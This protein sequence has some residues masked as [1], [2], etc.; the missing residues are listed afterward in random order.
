M[1]FAFA[2]ILFIT[3][4][5]T[6]KKT[7]NQSTASLTNTYWKLSKIN[8]KPVITPENAK[9]VHI[10]FASS[11][12][13]LQGFAG[14]N[15]LGGSYLLTGENNIKINAIT[16]KM[17]CDR[18]EVENFLTN[19]I[20]KADNYRIDGE[21]LSLFEGKKLLATFDSVYF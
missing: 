18:M 5:S 17:F 9:E 1:K 20:T 11:E 7:N 4:C 8:E 21:K 14:C 15:G 16:T 2:F 10:K 3:A 6:T 13:R 12:N 19:A